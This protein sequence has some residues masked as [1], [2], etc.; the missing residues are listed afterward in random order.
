MNSWIAAGALA[1]IGNILYWEMLFKYKVYYETI[2]GQRYTK[3]LVFKEY[4]LTDKFIYVF[5]LLLHVPIFFKL[6]ITSLLTV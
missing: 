2:G 4:N 6:I 5:S 3:I 1:L